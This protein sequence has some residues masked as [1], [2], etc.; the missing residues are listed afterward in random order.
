M[1]LLLG[2]NKSARLKPINLPFV[3]IFRVNMEKERAGAQIIQVWPRYI[4]ILDLL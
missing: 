2:D 3:R 1:V 4:A